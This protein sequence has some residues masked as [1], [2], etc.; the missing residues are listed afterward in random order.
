MTDYHEDGAC[1]AK[2]ARIRELNDQLRKAGIG[3]KTMLTR[4]VAELSPQALRAL[5]LAV[6]AFDDFTRA[7]DPWAEHDFGS[8]TVD[9][10]T[11][12]WKIDYYDVNL[13]FGSPDPA[14]ES[15]T[16]RVLTIM[17]AGDL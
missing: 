11:F 15:I 6:R 8:V 10:Q 4:A 7:N 2:R 3:G 13:E 17:T 16:R 14:D 12:F 9:G 5:L 1:P